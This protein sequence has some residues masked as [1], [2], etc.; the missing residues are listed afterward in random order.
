MLVGCVPYS[1]SLLPSPSPFSPSPR[2][3]NTHWASMIITITNTA[4]GHRSRWKEKHSTPA[5]TQDIGTFSLPS[6]HFFLWCLLPWACSVFGLGIYGCRFAVGSLKSV[7]NHPWEIHIKDHM[8]GPLS[9]AQGSCERFRV[10]LS[11]S[12]MLAKVDSARS[13]ARAAACF[14]CSNTVFTHWE[15]SSMC[16]GL[17]YLVM[18][19]WFYTQIHQY[20]WASETTCMGIAQQLSPKQPTFIMFSL[21]A[22][23]Q[24][25]I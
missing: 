12:W 17:S 23:L 18:K 11:C 14:F 20:W 9:L 16:C 19:G 21:P 3:T 15:N 1:P 5:R 22:V 24:P 6:N 8:P 4:S 2:S 10:C 25:K 7:Q 13:R